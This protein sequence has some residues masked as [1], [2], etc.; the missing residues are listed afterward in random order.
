MEM[1]D[2]LAQNDKY[3]KEELKKVFNGTDANKADNGFKD[4]LYNQYVNMCLTLDQ[5]G[6]RPESRRV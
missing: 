4:N 3:F 1:W 2:E 5:G 6:D